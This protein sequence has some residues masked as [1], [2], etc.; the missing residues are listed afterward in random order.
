M[1]TLYI[2]GKLDVCIYRKKFNLIDVSSTHQPST[3]TSAH[4]FQHQQSARLARQ[5]SLQA[6]ETYP[7]KHTQAT[8]NAGIG[9][10]TG[11]PH[12]AVR[13]NGIG[14]NGYP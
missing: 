4:Q 6:M 12:L 11:K 3:M 14:K 8:L 7:S 1:K 2:T 10:R 13:P 5:N 9:P